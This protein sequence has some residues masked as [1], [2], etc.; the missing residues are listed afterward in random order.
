MRR[1]AQKLKSNV[2][3]RRATTIS[4]PYIS[5]EKDKF[6]INIGSDEVLCNYIAGIWKYDSDANAY[7]ILGSGKNKA[8]ENSLLITNKNIYAITVPLEEIGIESSGM[9]LS[10]WQWLNMQKEIEGILKKMLN[11]MMLEEL[12]NSCIN[13]IQ[14]SK[15]N[16]KSIKTNDL[17]N[18]LAIVTKDKRKYHYSIRHNE[19]YER[20]QKIF[21]KMI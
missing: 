3:H 15:D 4:T 19:D 16:I 10:K 7:E 20:A 21:A 2:K 6:V 14:I 8:P 1:G 12:I 17:S 5:G 11:T 18:G 9:N 13:Y